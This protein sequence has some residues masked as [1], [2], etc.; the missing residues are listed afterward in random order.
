MTESPAPRTG[1]S[2]QEVLSSQHSRPQT[3][4][5]P[6][7]LFSAILQPNDFC[8][9]LTGFIGFYLRAFALPI[10]STW[11]FLLLEIFAGWPFIL[12]LE[13]ELKGHLMRKVF[14][15]PCPEST[16]PDPHLGTSITFPSAFFFCTFITCSSPL[17]YSFI[18]FHIVHIYH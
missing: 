12:S 4:W 9:V 7:I 18:C 5:S 14:P 6:F 1:P 8:L 13:S 15:I 2:T 17:M 3:I 11:K 16:A 10:L